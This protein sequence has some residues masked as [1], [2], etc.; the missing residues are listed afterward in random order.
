MITTMV[1]GWAQDRKNI[2][3]VGDEEYLSFPT[4]KF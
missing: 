2:F 1:S 3:M 4:G